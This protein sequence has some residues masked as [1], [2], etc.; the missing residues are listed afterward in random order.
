M[1]ISFQKIIPKALVHLGIKR[2]SSAALI[3]E[4]YRKCA[5][6]IVHKEALLHTFPKFYRNKIL[7]IAVENSVWAAQVA[8]QKM[9]LMEAINSSLGGPK[10]VEN[11]R[12]QVV[13][14]EMFKAT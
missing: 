4:K 2:E 9:A 12:T 13:P 7:T 10:S 8:K 3:C 6:K 14:R 1:Y 11:I 5:E